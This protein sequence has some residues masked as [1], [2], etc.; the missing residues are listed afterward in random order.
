MKSP[1]HGNEW[2]KPGNRKE[3]EQMQMSIDFRF[4]IKISSRLIAALLKALGIQ[5][6]Q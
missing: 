2:G 4:A 5:G 3:A 1:T 6:V